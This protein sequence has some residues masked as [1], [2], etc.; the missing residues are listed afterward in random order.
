[1]SIPTIAAAPPGTITALVAGSVVAHAVR[2]AIGSAGSEPMTYAEMGRRIDAF[3]GLLASEGI[4]R[5]ERVAILGENCPEWVIA[6]HGILAIGAVAVP[7]LTKFTDEDVRHVLR[8]S[9]ASGVVLTPKDIARLEGLT[10]DR[11]RLLFSLDG[12][13]L[14]EDR[15]KKPS[16]L[17]RAAALLAPHK[18]VPAS[19]PVPEDLAAIVY[20]SGTTGRSK[21]VMLTHANIATD[22]VASF[23]LFVIHPE[24]IFLS[25]LPLAHTYEAT[26][27]MLCPLASG[28]SVI[29]MKGVPTAENLLSAMGKV[30]PTAVL[31][32]PLIIEKIY[33]KKILPKLTSGILMRG[34]FSVSFIRRRLHQAA[35]KKLV[36]TFGGRLRFLMFGGAPL[37]GDVEAFLL[38]A[39]IA[40]STGYGMTETSPIMT[41]NPMGRVRS[42]SCGLPI[43]GIELRIDSPDADGVG[44]IVVRGPIVT[45]GYF[46][47][48]EATKDLFLGDGWLRTGDLGSFDADGYLFIRG[49]SKNVIIGA[50]GENIYP[51]VIEDRL[52]SSRLVAEVLVLEEGG[53][54]TAK[55]Y[56]DGDA[57]DRELHRRGGGESVGAVAGILEEIRKEANRGLPEFSRIARISQH[58]EPFEKTPTNKVKR[59][60]YK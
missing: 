35:G 32:V 51:E 44:E 41:I 14:L 26:G 15:R 31:T 3:A 18:T 42:G 38:D 56:L 6:Y 57:L 29:F 1:M 2:P 60:L 58:A 40:Y 21:G 12:L 47:N 36:E 45:Q 27:G 54:V 39:G 22:A 48:P 55:V 7:I 25:I 30:R 49:R 19:P 10:D 28:C 5:G 24:D 16:L 46:K 20:T 50:S 59:Y 52:L 8:H 9:E 4:G 37:A 13:T 17:A 34:L 33:R 11:V 43:K 53:K 23:S